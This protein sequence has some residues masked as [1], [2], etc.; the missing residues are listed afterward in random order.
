MSEETR[1]LLLLAGKLLTF[2]LGL[3][4]VVSSQGAE[5]DHTRL[6][7]GL[8]ILWVCALWLK[9]YLQTNGN[10][11]QGWLSWAVSSVLAIIPGA[12][13]LWFGIFAPAQPSL[14]NSGVDVCQFQT[15]WCVSGTRTFIF[16]G[17]AV[18]LAG[19]AWSYF[20]FTIEKRA[21]RKEN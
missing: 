18:L 7:V 11:G 19:L 9:Q 4:L 15:G 16:W 3:W 6:T 17:G 5:L 10:L 2:A 20:M 1:K 13:L 12:I 21:E 14:T 8:L